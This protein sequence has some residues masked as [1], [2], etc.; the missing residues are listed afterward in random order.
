MAGV[1][2]PQRQLVQFAVV[3]RQQMRLQVE[4]DLQPVLDLPQEGVV[5]LEDRPFEAAQAAGPLQ[6]GERLERVAGADLGQVAAVEQLEELDHELDVADAAAAGFHVADASAQ[7]EGLLLDPPLQGLDAADVGVA[8]VA[9]V[10]PRPKRGEKLV[11][12]REV[13]GH[14]PGLDV[15]LP[16][17]G[18]AA[19]VVIRHRALDA[20]DHRPASPFRPQPHIDPVDPAQ[21]GLL[22]Q[23]ADE[24]AGHKV[25]EFEIADWPRAVGRAVVFAEEDQ[26]DVAGVV[27]FQ[28]AELA[29]S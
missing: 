28:A 5:L 1:A 18:P 9:A 19:G 13:A 14:R 11:A 10:D 24:F 2:H 17:P 8:Q 29:Q 27:Q 4:H 23:Q 22:G 7:T 25:E 20:H 21:L 15:G 26:V 6:P 12:Q 16:L 3:R